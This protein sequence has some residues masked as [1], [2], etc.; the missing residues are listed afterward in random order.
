MSQRKETLEFWNT[1][2]RE[3]ELEQQQQNKQQEQPEQE[4]RRQTQFE[5]ERCE[6]LNK[7]WII[8]PNEALLEKLFESFFA[9]TKSLSELDEKSPDKGSLS[10]SLRILEI[11]CG[12]STL[13]RDVYLYLQQHLAMSTFV[14]KNNV[15]I[16]EVMATDAS[17]V[18]IAQMRKRDAQWLKREHESNNDRGEQ[19]QQQSGLEYQVLNLTEPEED[20]HRA[21]QNKFDFI[22]DKGC[23]DTFLFRSRKRGQQKCQIIHHPTAKSSSAEPAATSAS[24]HAAVSYS[25][26]L[27]LV[28]MVLDHVWSWLK[29]ET[30]R[31]LIL[32]PR[33]KVVREV[34]DYPGF[35]SPIRRHVLDA[36]LFLIG[37]LDGNAKDISERGNKKNKSK[38]DNNDKT[39]Q[40][41]LSSSTPA[42]Q[43]YLY[44]CIKIKEESGLDRALLSS[45]PQ[46]TAAAAAAATTTTAIA[47]DSTCPVCAMTFYEYRKGECF[48]GRG[49][50]FWNRRWLGHMRHCRAG[51][52]KVCKIGPVAS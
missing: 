5:T 15:T 37:D 33:S 4:Q 19:Q 13:S 14:H 23:L 7:E 48:D 41:N 20:Q 35:V 26:M 18:C 38:T 27:P 6:S 51:R 46:A 9:E 1:F 28:K 31:Y 12:T 10:P 52:L 21:F 42:Q 2:Y 30:G 22:L 16:L 29:P 40:Q 17:P 8:Q 39:Q 36:N 50:S 43:C 34:R 24:P 32:T 47:D 11:G 3:Q 45:L 49:S 25:Y 44:E